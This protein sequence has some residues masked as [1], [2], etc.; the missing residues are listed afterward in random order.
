MTFFL[1]FNFFVGLLIMSC[2]AKIARGRKPF[3]AIVHRASSKKLTCH[4]SA[5]ACAI[6]AVKNVLNSTGLN[7]KFIY[8]LACQKQS[9]SY[10]FSRLTPGPRSLN[11]PFFYKN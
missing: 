7:A 5:A 11:L 9:C 10:F 8:I 4:A 6:T 3:K 1:F 2:V